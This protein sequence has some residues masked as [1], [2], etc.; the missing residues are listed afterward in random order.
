MRCRYCGA[1]T[2]EHEARCVRCQRRISLDA[3]S[4]EY[5][6]VNNLAV[7][8]D[9]RPRSAEAPPPRGR[10][11]TLLGGADQPVDQRVP[12]R[13]QDLFSYRDP[14]RPIELETLSTPTRAAAHK[15][16]ADSLRAETHRTAPRRKT[17]ANQT[18]F[19]FD[20][21]P[22]RGVM[23]NVHSIESPLPV[24]P[25]T[26]RTMSALFD[27]G[28]VALLTMACLFCARLLLGSLPLT[29]KALPYYIATAAVISVVYKL[30]FT[31]FGATTLG[32]QGAGLRLIT[33]DGLRP[34]PGQQFVRIVAGALAL[35]TGFGVLWPLCN[36][37][38]LT[39]ADMA[40][41]SYLTAITQR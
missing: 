11:E 36:E 18:A 3:A 16:A 35:G 21:A 26:L 25:L 22:S 2:P 34:T 9:L 39:W 4:G 27:T 23:R 31:A 29:L 6:T 20:A 13:Q 5:P 32:I 14:A 8:P 15:R 37:E 38:Q 24:A 7:A 1:E 33:Y 12:P 10:F 41:Q 28:V 40:S 19:D 17:S 30:L